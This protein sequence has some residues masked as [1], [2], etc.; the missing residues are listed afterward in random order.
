MTP[1]SVRTIA[2]ASKVATGIW[3]VFTLAKLSAKDS[4]TCFYLAE[5]S[6][7]HILAC[8]LFCRSSAKDFLPS[9]AAAERSATHTLASFLLAAAAAGDFLPS[10]QLA[11]LLQ[12]L[13]YPPAPLQKLF[14]GKFTHQHV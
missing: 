4:L 10:E 6:T 14:Q 12:P 9:R 7:T 11:E 5:A 1:K 13:P 3:Q 2:P 8:F